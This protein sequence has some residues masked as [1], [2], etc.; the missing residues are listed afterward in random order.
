MSDILTATPRTPDFSGNP[1]TSDPASYNARYT[2]SQLSPNLHTFVVTLTVK[3]SDKKSF[4]DFILPAWR[5]GRYQIQNYAASVQEFEAFSEKQLLAFEKT[6]KQTWRVATDGKAEV[7]V[8]YKYYAGNPIDAGNTYCGSEEMYFNGSNLFVYTDETRNSPALL[9]IDYP[10]DWKV[11]SQL[12]PLGGKSFDAE[13]Y[14][15][16]IDAP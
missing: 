9:T 15:D 12:R 3:N 16:L 10:D 14:D 5:P 6:D 7:Q 8:R 11:A 1:Q 2:L 4:V 13:T